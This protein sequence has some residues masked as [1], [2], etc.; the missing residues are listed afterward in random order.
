M[1]TTEGEKVNEVKALKHI[2]KATDLLIEIS[3]ELEPTSIE[4]KRFGDAINYLD[5]LREMVTGSQP[6][7]KK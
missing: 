2:D 7:E 6:A 1:A 3:S 4:W 5:F